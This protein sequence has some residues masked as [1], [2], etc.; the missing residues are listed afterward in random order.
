MRIIRSDTELP[1]AQRG[2][3]ITVQIDGRPVAA[4]AGETVAGLLLAEGIRTFR[5]TAKLG[6]A[7]S[8]FCGIGIC[9]DCLVTVDGTPN[10]RACMTLLAP[11]MAIETRER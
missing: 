11:G 1:L 8:I 6:E 9:Y 4:F 3:S 7:R 2:E 5:H 10:I